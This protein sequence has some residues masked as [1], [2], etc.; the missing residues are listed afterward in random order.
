[1]KFETLFE[2]ATGNAP[3]PYQSRF[4]EGERLPELLSVPT[5]VGKTATAILGWLYRRRFAAKSVQKVTPRRLVY[6][7][8]MRTLVEQTEG[9]AR[10][11]LSKLGVHDEVG[12]HVLMGGLDRTDWDEW[13]E[14]DA[15]LIGTQDMLLSRALNRGYGMSRYRWPMHFGL[16]NS[17]CLW[18]LDELQLMG[19]GLASTSQLQ[20]FRESIGTIGTVATVWMSATLLPRWLASVDYRDRIEPK[21]QLQ[22]LALDPKLD[23]K[24]DGLRERWSAKKPLLPAKLSAD[25]PAGIAAFVQGKHHESSLTLVIVNTVDRCRTLF[26]ELK[27][28]YQPP[29][30]KRGAKKQA[31]TE[32]PPPAPE[33][34]LV[35]SR[36]RP[37]EREGW[38]SLFT[39]KDLPAAGRIIVST[40]V[41]EAGVDMSA[42]TL[43]TELAPWPSLVQR[44]GRCNRSG[45]FSG[46]NSAQV[47]WIDVPTPDEKKA[48]PYAKAELDEARTRLNGIV[49]VGLKSLTGFF[50]ELT[51]EERNRLF[52][53]DP[54]HV[55]RRKD[56]IDL[57]DTT[58]DLAG[59]DIDVSRFIRDGDE[60][61]VQVFWR[62]SV[63]PKGEITRN[64]ARQLA[65]AREELCTVKIADFREFLDGHTAH[66]WDSLSSEW[67][68]ADAATVYPGQVYWIAKSEGGYDAQLGWSPRAEWTDD[69]W[70]RDPA[71]ESESDTTEEPGYD[72]EL[73]SLYMWQSIAQHTQEVVEAL[74]AILKELKFDE[75]PAAALLIAA[76]WHDWGKAHFVFQDAIRD[77]AEGKGQRP[78]KWAGKRDL[79]K[80][81]P[82]D[83]W[84]NYKRKHFRHEL[85]SALGVLTLLK[86]GQPPDNWQSLDAHLTNLALYLI[87][88][89]HGKVRLSI[90]SLPD[91]C[92]PAT[93]GAL[94]ARG[95]WEA[96][97][98]PSVD[99]GGNVTAPALA[100]L[101]LSPMLLGRGKDGQ[102][103]WAE[104]MLRLR[105]DKSNDH[106]RRFGPLKL[107]YLEALIRAADIRASKT[108]DEKARKVKEA[109][110]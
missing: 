32:P 60:I 37:K 109:Q 23:Y 36:F 80:A 57:F 15:I 40:Q 97:P 71:P 94:F 105:D 91:E 87:A 52:P 99:L 12:V 29:K 108:A 4:A 101:D 24:V 85:A 47:F 27:K 33:L 5:G 11:W 65:P 83:V 8:P 41:V 104:R 96:D 100:A 79:A 82:E 78:L 76:R 102:P 93:A 51:E 49:D 39:A 18:V 17:D 53:F 22:S 66:R 59:N 13:P 1:M 19:T 48:A 35:H 73:M 68:K 16:L 55:I 50:H 14:R 74:E 43:I 54:L 67:V 44:F 77:D 9:C 26:T 6:C 30:A 107:A 75:I 72:T 21:L 69:L 31:V 61:D 2:R 89:H 62:A 45:E 7:L 46:N 110:T 92:E 34:R 106:A 103:S 86:S 38:Q 56:F 88:A 98:L 95:V 42:R 84:C 64:L 58:P 28:R 3:Y 70:L 10:T 20:A 90:R 25:D 63:P 81:A